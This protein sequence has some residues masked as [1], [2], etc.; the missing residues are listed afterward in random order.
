MSLALPGHHPI[1]TIICWPYAFFY[2][3]RRR[4]VTWVS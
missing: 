1:I 3:W 2:P 4:S